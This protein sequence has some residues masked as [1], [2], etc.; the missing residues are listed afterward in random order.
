MCTVTEKG[1]CSF[2]LC[3][4]RDIAKMENVDTNGERH[5]ELSPM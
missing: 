2:E 5:K 3:T 4:V 1:G